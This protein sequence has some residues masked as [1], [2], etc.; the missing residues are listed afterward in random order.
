MERKGFKSRVDSSFDGIEDPL[1]PFLI[2]NSED[3]ENFC[4]Q[5]ERCGRGCS[6]A[7][8]HSEYYKNQDS[9]VAAA[10]WDVL[11]PV[12]GANGAEKKDEVQVTPEEVEVVVNI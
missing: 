8:S 9:K 7:L 3:P 5:P 4:L 6:R 11:D 1:Q 10:T 2:W 12:C